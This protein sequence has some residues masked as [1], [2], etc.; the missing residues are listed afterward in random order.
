MG[1]PRTY[2]LS[3]LLPRQAGVPETS[4]SE[5]PSRPGSPT[6]RRSPL[7]QL[8][9]AGWGRGRS[10]ERGQE[11]RGDKEAS[12]YRRAAGD[13]FKY[14]ILIPVHGP[15]GFDGV[16]ELSFKTTAGGDA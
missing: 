13:G 11:Y 16:L 1:K 5:W 8:R 2:T 15:G 4:S 6:P 10:G 12:V 3:S 7:R 9:G 14:N